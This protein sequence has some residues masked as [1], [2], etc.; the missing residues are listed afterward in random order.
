MDSAGALID[1]AWRARREGRLDEAERGLRD[2]ID[3]T[4][5]A[6]D[7]DHLVDALGKLAHVMRDLDRPDAALPL[8]E[9]AVRLGRTVH[10]ALR[11]A[12]ALRHLG[13][14]HRGAARLADADRCYSEALTI[15]R[16]AGAPD[17]L[18]FANAL[19]PAA[20]LKHAIGDRIAA[21]ELFA[22]A[23]DRYREAGIDAGVQECARHLAQLE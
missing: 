15:Y 8:L 3:A 1:A 11:L 18:D 6:G 4:R 13:D 21:R 19:R 22:E 5:V 2:A 20:L 7:D 14:L 17:A 12:H 10:D 16:R 23:R 9:E